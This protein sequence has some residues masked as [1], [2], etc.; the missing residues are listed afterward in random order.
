MKA[1]TPGRS[2]RPKGDKRARTRARILDAAAEVVGE[3][4]WDRTSL[5]AVAARAGMTRGAIYG[6]FKNRDDLFLAIVQTRWRPVIPTYQPG[7]SFK[8]RMQVLGRAVASAGPERRTQAVGAL[9][10]MLFA[11]THEDMRQ[12]VVGLNREIYKQTAARIAKSV[13]R[14]E[15]PMAPERLVKVLHALSDGLTFLRFLAPE[16]I[17]DDVIVAAFEALAVSRGKG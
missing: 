11:L 5:E 10:F 6:N 7:M 1:P 12:R 15:L 8:E 2:A 9:S 14:A 3:Q 17:T 4:G 16:L 13:G